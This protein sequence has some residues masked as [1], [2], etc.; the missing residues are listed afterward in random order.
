MLI[1]Y[2]YEN[3]V[4][5]EIGIDQQLNKAK[6]LLK[7]FIHSRE[8]S[9][10][11]LKAL[12]LNMPNLIFLLVEGENIANISGL[13]SLS[14]LAELAVSYNKIGE[15]PQEIRALKKLKEFY[16]EYN[17]ILSL[18]KEIATLSELEVLYFSG[19]K[20]KNL[21]K[22]I[23]GIPH[24]K[25]AYFSENPFDNPVIREMSDALTGRVM[26]NEIA[27]FKVLKYLI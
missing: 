9:I 18:P 7:C 4:E 15:I 22:E 14:N 8:D 21:P 16:I 20:I 10:P 23:V 11:C 12:P 17:Q 2:F 5:L 6:N 27:F 1:F 13:A 25:M 3:K 24:L 26:E 19:N